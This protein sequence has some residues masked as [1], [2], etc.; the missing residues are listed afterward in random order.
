M[1][2]IFPWQGGWARDILWV[3]LE[4]RC[5]PSSTRD[6]DSAS[7]EIY[8]KAQT[9]LLLTLNAN[10][11]TTNLRSYQ[12]FHS[13][14]YLTSH[15]VEALSVNRPPDLQ[16]ISFLVLELALSLSRAPTQPLTRVP[17]FIYGDPRK[18]YLLDYAVLLGLKLLDDF[19]IHISTKTT[20]RTLKRYVYPIHIDKISSSMVYAAHY[21]R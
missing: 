14:S 7:S 16:L 5:I 11:R 8:L 9:T 13:L 19:A 17:S 18:R 2:Q 12:H 10:G 15:R 3:K 1:T 21:L 4:K 6:L 20:W